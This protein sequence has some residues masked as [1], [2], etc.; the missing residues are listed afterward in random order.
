MSRNEKLFLLLSFVISLAVWSY[1]VS[2]EFSI[3]LIVSLLIHEYGHYWWMG[4]DGVQNRTM[5]FFPP[6]GAMAMAKD[7]CPSYG[8]E[9]RIALAGPIFGFIP[10][11]LAGILWNITGMDI[12]GASIV[13]ICWINLFNAAVPIPI[14]DGGHV[15]KA[16]LFS[17]H[18]QLGIIFYVFGFILT[19]FIFLFVLRSP[20]FLFILFLLYQDFKMVLVAK[21]NLKNTEEALARLTEADALVFMMSPKKI[22]EERRDLF[23]KICNMPKM[24]PK[25]MFNNLVCLLLINAIYVFVLLQ[26]SRMLNISLA[27]ETFLNFFK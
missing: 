26:V 6:F 2:W 27:S 20:V 5:F 18:Y 24:A 23:N 9:S 10:A 1:L 16:V 11:V 17:I 13:L 8:A 12:F 22:L 4:K 7:I 15:I 19:I 3:I 21:S 14:L 25:E